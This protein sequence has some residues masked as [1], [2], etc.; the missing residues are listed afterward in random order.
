MALVMLKMQLKAQK[1]TQTK[2]NSVLCQCAV[3]GICELLYET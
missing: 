3:R 2:Y 1:Q